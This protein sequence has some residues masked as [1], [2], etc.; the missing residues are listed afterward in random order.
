MQARAHA[1][2]ALKTDHREQQQTENPVAKDGTRHPMDG[3]S[4]I[5]SS[6]EQMIACNRTVSN[7]FEKTYEPIHPVRHRRREVFQG[8]TAQKTASEGTWSANKKNCSLDG[9]DANP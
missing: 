2:L 6:D 3:G 7:S 5:C 8:P 9:K 4:V 1:E